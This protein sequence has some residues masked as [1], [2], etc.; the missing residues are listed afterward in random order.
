MN[1]FKERGT[2]VLVAL[3]KWLHLQQQAADAVEELHELVEPEP[4]PPTLVEW[5][6]RVV[7]LLLLLL[8]VGFV[9]TEALRPPTPISFD[10]H[11]QTS[12]IHQQGEAW[13]VPV[14]LRN[15]GS[16]SAQE[17]SFLAQL[18]N[19]AGEPVE[20]IEVSLPLLGA[21]E[22]VGLELWFSEDPRSHTLIF[23]VQS[24]RLP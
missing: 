13:V 7:S 12:A 17:L 3:L 9:L 6:A 11:V 19:T 24:Y 15:Q 2:G 1:S 20:E 23:D 21:G 5:A 18:T 8:L 16:R 22:A 10:Y 4:T 14:T